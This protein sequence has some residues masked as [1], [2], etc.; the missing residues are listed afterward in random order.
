MLNKIFS[1]ITK[2][3]K[4]LLALLFVVT[5]LLRFPGLGYSHFY[6]D[7]TKTLYWNKTIPAETFLMEQ[8]K[9]PV[10]FVAVWFMETLT[11]GFDEFAIRL[12]FAVAGTLA[13]F[14]FYL[15]VRKLFNWQIAIIATFLFATNGFMVAFSRTAQYQSFLLLFGLLSVYLATFDTK[16]E[17]L[18]SGVFLGLAFLS[19]YDAVFLAIPTIYIL[20]K[21]FLEAKDKRL[22]FIHFL[23][24]LIP[25]ILI[26]G[27]FYMPYIK[28]GYFEQNTTGYITRRVDKV[29]GATNTVLTHS[30]YNPYIVSLLLFVVGGGFLFTKYRSQAVILDLWFTIPFVVFEALFLSSGTHVMHYFIP[31]FILTGIT[32]FAVYEWCKRY[33]LQDVMTILYGILLVGLIGYS[34]VTFIPS[35]S[36]GHPWNSKSLA[37]TKFKLFLYG[38]PY[39][40]GWDQV[41]DYLHEVGAKDF[42]TND[43]VTIGEFYTMGIPANKGLADYYVN[44]E[45]NQEYVEFNPEDVIQVDYKRVHEIKVDGEKVATIYK[46]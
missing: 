15:V 37:T 32:L 21:R 30:V 13:V 33:S 29:G 35:F 12:P 14:V 28:G 40:R 16:R 45:R 39:Y 41:G 26:V 8:R 36:K 25:L 6:G 10:Q 5:V 9:G 44:V 22:T 1:K 46:K 4:W 42:Y 23:Y 27:A 18:L 2:T 17:M 34:S 20:G 31:G 24:F 38:F 3:E 19:H 7:E 43:N 11:G